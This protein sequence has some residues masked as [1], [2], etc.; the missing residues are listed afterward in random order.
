MVNNME[1]EDQYNKLLTE[2]GLFF[3]GSSKG[4]FILPPN[5][6]AL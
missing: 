5:G 3:H 4:N 6:Y 2:G 1:K